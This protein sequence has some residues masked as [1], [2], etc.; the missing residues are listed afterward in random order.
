MAIDTRTLGA[1]EL[2]DLEG[3]PQRISSAWR[4]G[5]AVLVFLRHFG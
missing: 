3:R 1:L 2:L 4:S 5:P